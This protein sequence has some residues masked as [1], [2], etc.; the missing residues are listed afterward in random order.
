M[1]AGSNPVGTPTHAV[2]GPML[3][4]HQRRRIHARST[5]ANECASKLL[6]A[7]ARQPVTKTQGNRT[8]RR[9]TGNPSILLTEPHG[10]ARHSQLPKLDSSL[11][12]RGR[13]ASRQVPLLVPLPS[14][15]EA[16]LVSISRRGRE[17]RTGPQV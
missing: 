16:E 3:G 5:S 12:R 15:H 11:S 10:I 4:D 13:R 7:A 14:R 17:V 1:N 8:S 9:A 2:H 6:F